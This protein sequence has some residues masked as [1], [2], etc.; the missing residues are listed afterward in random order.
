MVI[1]IYTRIYRESHPAVPAAEIRRDFLDSLCLFPFFV[2][3]W[4]NTEPL[5]HLMDSTFPVRFL[6]S[7]ES[8]ILHFLAE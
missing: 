7:W 1:D 4:F 2:A 3:V 6:K 8:Y 5:D